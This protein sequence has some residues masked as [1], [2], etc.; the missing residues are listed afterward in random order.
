M[1]QEIINVSTPNDG[2]GDPLRSAMVK[3]NAMFTELYETVVFQEAGKGLSSNDFTDEEQVKLGGIEAGA[4]VNVQADM[5]QEDETADS[6]V[7]NKEL[8]QLIRKP[9]QIEIYVLVRLLFRTVTK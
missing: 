7:Q 4:E 1:A 6:F 2:Q 3:V 5:A 9:S 8:F